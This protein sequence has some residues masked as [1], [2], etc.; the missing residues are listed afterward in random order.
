MID[1]NSGKLLEY[2]VF[3]TEEVVFVKFVNPFRNCIYWNGWMGAIAMVDYLSDKFYF[4]WEYQGLYCL[5]K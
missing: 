4:I 1:S 5:Q 3:V 2:F